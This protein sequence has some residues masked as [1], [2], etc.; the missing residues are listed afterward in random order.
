MTVGLP[1]PRKKARGIDFVLGLGL[2]LL[3]AILSFLPWK[4]FEVPQFKLY[5]LGLRIR[6][7]IPVP[8][9]VIIAAIDDASVAT[10]G[11]WPW[12][13]QKIAEL[14]DDLSQAGAKIIAVDLTFLPTESERLSG[15]DRVLAEAI[16]RA[17]NVVLPFYFT[18]GESQKEGRKA[19]T[20]PQVSSSAFLLFDDPRKFSDFP[21]PSAEKIFASVPEIARAARAMGHINVL[22]DP[23]GKVRWEP[24]IIH[25]DGQ[26]YPSFSTQVA[27]LA[28][29]LTR[30][31]VRVTVGRSI[32]FPTKPS[33]SS[34]MR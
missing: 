29:G 18:L 8:K 12:P 4:S 19:E 28:T 25:F 7:A 32:H 17:G 34:R 21:P 10:L 9:E 5:D 33:G 15:N 13:R 2:T 24:L 22:P 27:A 20:L 30:G 1:N 16:Q 26:Y 3:V 23:D 6:G 11:R 14:I 31:D